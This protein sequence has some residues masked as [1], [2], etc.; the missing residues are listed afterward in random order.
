MYVVSRN[1]APV[2]VLQSTN[3]TGRFCD[4]PARA[5][6]RYGALCATAAASYPPTRSLFRGAFC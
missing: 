1:S 3:L 5:T 2:V 6:L 4:L